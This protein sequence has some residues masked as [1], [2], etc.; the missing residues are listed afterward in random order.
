V[1]TNAPRPVVGLRA[2]DTFADVEPLTA[3]G[4]ALERRLAAVEG[5][6]LDRPSSCSGWS[7][8]VSVDKVRGGGHRYLLLMQGVLAE[9][10]TTGTRDHV[11]PHPLEAYQRWRRPLAAAFTKPG[12]LDPDR[13]PPGRGP[14]AA[15]PGGR[16]SAAGAVASDRAVL[17]WID[18]QTRA[19]S[20]CAAHAG[21]SRNSATTRRSSPSRSRWSPP[22][23]ISQ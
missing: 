18:L 22:V 1:C 3:A 16:F 12:A 20:S 2:T 10:L 9:E 17:L 5:G 11:R 15:A 13:A 19:V 14:V 4:S 8:Y 21:A 23:S 7:V 6:E